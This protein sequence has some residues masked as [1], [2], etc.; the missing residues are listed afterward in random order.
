[1]LNYNP[2]WGNSSGEICNFWETVIRFSYNYSQHHS[3]PEWW[4][5]TSKTSAKGKNVVGSAPPIFCVSKILWTEHCV[6]VIYR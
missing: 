2:G 5:L 4:R 3:G 1:M 6:Y